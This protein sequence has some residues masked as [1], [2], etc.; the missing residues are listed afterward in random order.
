MKSLKEYIYYIN[1]NKN[2]LKDVLNFINNHADE[3]EV[4]ELN[5][6]PSE[7]EAYCD[8][9]L[10]SKYKGQDITIKVIV[11]WD[12][13]DGE[14]VISEGYWNDWE[15]FIDGTYFNSF[16]LDI[17]DEVSNVADNF[18][19]YFDASFN[20]ITKKEWKAGRNTVN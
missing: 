4:Y 12:K 16:N 2:N 8:C 1:E 11:T 6:T 13:E 17:N 14:I 18:N 10:Q 15:I 7:E 19:G 3:I 20:K 9:K 5:Y